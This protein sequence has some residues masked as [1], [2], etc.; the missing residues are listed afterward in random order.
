MS[1]TRSEQ[2]KAIV[3]QLDPTL[4]KFTPLNPDGMALSERMP[5]ISLRLLVI[6]HLLDAA[7]GDHL[8][9]ATPSPTA[10]KA[11]E[12]CLV[13]G[14]QDADSR[15]A[16]ASGGLLPARFVGRCAVSLLRWFFR[17][18]TPRGRLLARRLEECRP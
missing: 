16:D 2:L 8:C 18:F 17:T 13:P 15:R 3:Q 7:S 11:R 4:P 14:S 1:K 6:E 12:G 5:D 10:D 9:G